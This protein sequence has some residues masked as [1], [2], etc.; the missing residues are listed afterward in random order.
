MLRKQDIV[1]CA[2]ALSYIAGIN[3]FHRFDGTYASVKL[4]FVS[5]FLVLTALA[6]TVPFLLVKAQSRTIAKYLTWPTVL[7]F[8]MLLCA[9]TGVHT[10]FVSNKQIVREFR[11]DRTLS[12]LDRA[13]HFG[14]YPYALLALLTHSTTVVRLLDSLYMFWFIILILSCILALWSSRDELRFRYLLSALLVWSGLGTLLSTLFS[15]AGPCYYGKIVPGPNPYAPLMSALMDI[16][17]VT[18]LFAIK[19]QA[20]LWNNYIFHGWMP[21]GGISAMPS[22]HV[23]MAVLFAIAAYRMN[24]KLGFVFWAYAL[25]IQVASVVLGWH[26]AI[27]GYLA[28]AV[29]VLIWHFTGFL[30]RY[31]SPQALKTA[32]PQFVLQS[33]FET[34]L[35]TE[36]D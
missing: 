21:F 8:S 10:S 31:V 16:N 14:H 3:L 22:L 28:T 36:A 9:S 19:N 4:S 23:G 27:D 34:R 17:S 1:I 26:Y 30:Y 33:S 2:A 6:V 29:T 18:P 20:G 15:S 7:G 5:P 25:S 13:I 11:W 24:P 35:R 32:S 12:Q